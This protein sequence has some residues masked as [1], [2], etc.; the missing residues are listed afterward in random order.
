MKT[1]SSQDAP[2]TPSDL[3]PA[4]EEDD[5]AGDVDP[6]IDEDVL[7]EDDLDTDRVTRFD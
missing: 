6:G 5:D 2:V 1:R 7:D 3:R 4:R